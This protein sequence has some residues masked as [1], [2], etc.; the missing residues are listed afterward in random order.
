MLVLNYGNC[1]LFVNSFLFFFY[2]ILC[3]KYL[4]KQILNPLENMVF[5]HILLK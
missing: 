3:D 2:K 4:L 5:G 1:I